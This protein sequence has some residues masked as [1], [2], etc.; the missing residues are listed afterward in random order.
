MPRVSGRSIGGGTGGSGTSGGT[1]GSTSGSSGSASSGGSS[2]STS[3]SI[4]SASSSGSPGRVS[5]FTSPP[6]QTATVVPPSMEAPVKPER[7]D[8]HDPSTEMS[9]KPFGDILAGSFGQPTQQTGVSTDPF[10]TINGEL[11]FLQ[12]EQQVIPQIPIEQEV[13]IVPEK[14]TRH[15][16]LAAS[17]TLLLPEAHLALNLKNL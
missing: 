13:P 17:R 12:P 15:R 11:A 5:V 7:V 2:G 16:N 4:G 8:V 14:G 10:R 1:G 3:G 6:P 9:F